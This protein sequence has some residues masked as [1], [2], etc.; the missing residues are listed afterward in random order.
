MKDGLQNR[1][2]A[3]VLIPRKVFNVEKPDVSVD[4]VGDSG[5]PEG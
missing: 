5:V 1:E 3:D 2:P 4:V